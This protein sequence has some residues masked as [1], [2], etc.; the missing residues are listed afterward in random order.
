M[1]KHLLFATVS[2]F[3]L[4]S[5]SSVF[6]ALITYEFG[7]FF[8]GASLVFNGHDTFSGSYT[9]EDSVITTGHV[10]STYDIRAIAG[11][12]ALLGTGWELEINSTTPHGNFTVSGPSIEILLG[13]DVSSYGDS[14]A[15]YLKGA[16]ALSLPGGAL[17]HQFNFQLTDPFSAGAD[18]LTSSNYAAL[19]LLGL[20]N[21]TGGTILTGNLTSNQIN[22]IV[23]TSLT[24]PNSRPSPVPEPS[25]MLLFGPGIAGLIGLRA[26]RKKK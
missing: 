5:V 20:A 2:I 18:L 4:L 17:F 14:Y 21:D 3:I 1:K 24:V 26:R 9:F 12:T 11:S 8:V 15:V 22:R 25:T 10:S 23:I 19:P 16:G 13:N 7:G 6:G